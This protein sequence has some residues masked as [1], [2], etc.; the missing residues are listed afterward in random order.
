MEGLLQGLKT[1][2]KVTFSEGVKAKTK[3][4]GK[5][6]PRDLKEVRKLVQ[7]NRYQDIVSR[8]SSVSKFEVFLSSVITSIGF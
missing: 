4:K 3:V 7:E 5:S 2:G 6:Y 1:E 8:D